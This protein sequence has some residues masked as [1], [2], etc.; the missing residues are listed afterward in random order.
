MPTFPMEL[1]NASLIELFES[2]NKI[3]YQS[4]L[5]TLV[6]YKTIPETD[7]PWDF[8]QLKEEL[9]KKIPKELRNWYDENSSCGDSTYVSV[10]AFSNYRLI[11]NYLAPKKN[12]EQNIELYSKELGITKIKVPSPVFIAPYGAANLYGGYSD[13]MNCVIGSNNVKNITYTIPSLTKY[14]LEEYGEQ[15][16]IPTMYQLYLTNDNDINISL[17]E[18]AKNIGVFVIMVTA[19]TPAAHGGLPMISTGSDITFC[20]KFCE[21]VLNDPVFN[22]KCYIAQKCVGTKDKKILEMVKL[23]LKVK[24]LKYNKNKA[25]N[26]A[27]KVQLGGMDKLNASTDLF[28]IS[29]ISKICHSN[30]SMGIFQNTFKKGVPLIIKGIISI[31]DALD[32]QSSGADGIYISTHGGRY[33]YNSP[34]PIDVLPEIKAAVKKNNLHFGVWFDGGIRHG[35]DIAIAINRGAEFVGIGR[36]II[37][38]NVLYGAVGVSAVL[39]QYLFQ[40]EQAL[41]TGI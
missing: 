9:E 37:Y 11:P 35:G 14:T 36:P 25:F 32:S 12:L 8:N 15:C 5:K 4:L 19:D 1:D 27:R 2:K 17:I 30:K 20:S 41:K 21:N 23:Y 31:K 28:S 13:E 18:R 38:A 26:F 33:L 34:A 16:K 22:I 7:V 40:L 39:Q 10:K 29:N 24:E 3:Y 6:K